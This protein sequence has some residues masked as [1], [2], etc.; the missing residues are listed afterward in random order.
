MSELAASPSPRGQWVPQLFLPNGRRGRGSFAKAFGIYALLAIAWW[1]GLMT[2]VPDP[3]G[4][5]WAL[6]LMISGFLLI[7]AGIALIAQRLHDLGWSGWWM[8][9]VWLGV[10][11]LQAGWNQALLGSILQLGFVLLIAILPGQEHENA[12]GPAPAR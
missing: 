6:L 8:V 1:G 5:G 9:P 11:V 2:H 3:W 4:H 7:V 10:V 12:F